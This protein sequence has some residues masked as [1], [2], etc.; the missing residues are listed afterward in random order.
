M[1][2][3]Y[4][5]PLLLS[6]ACTPPADNDT[7]D[8]GGGD[9]DTDTGPAACSDHTTLQVPP[10]L[11]TDNTTDEAKPLQRGWAFDICVDSTGRMS[12]TLLRSVR[13]AAE[14]IT[15]CYDADTYELA[16]RFQDCP[17]CDHDWELV[18]PNDSASGGEGQVSLG[19]HDETDG[20]FPEM[21]GIDADGN[22]G[23]PQLFVGFAG[24]GENTWTAYTDLAYDL[25]D[26]D[27][28]DGTH[29]G[30]SAYEDLTP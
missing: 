14:D 11:T 12:G 29:Y 9:T 1:K 6:A 2:P 18:S 25:V 4:G 16:P 30:F 19:C 15:I 10:T 28:T 5:V 27:A 22:A 17:G 20:F 13:V 3:W 8:S 21:M 7:D 26:N 23:E 24:E